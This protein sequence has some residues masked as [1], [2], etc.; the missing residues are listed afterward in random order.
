MTNKIRFKFNHITLLILCLLV[1]FAFVSAFGC[2][3]SGSKVEN[4]PPAKTTPVKKAKEVKPQSPFA[5][6]DVTLE[7]YPD[8]IK[9]YL[10]TRKWKTH[11]GYNDELTRQTLLESFKLG[12]AFMI[13]NQKPAGNFNY[14]YDFVTKTQDRGDNQVRQAGALWGLALTYQYKQDPA[15]KAALDKA[16]K[17]FFEHTRPGPIEGSLVVAYPGEKDSQSGTNALVALA[18]I[19]YLRTDKDTALN[20]PAEYKKQLKEKL[21]GYLKLLVWMKL[22]NKHFSKYYNL[23]TKT[24]TSRFSPY[25]DGETMLCLV[26]AA[27]YLGYKE[28]VPVIEDSALTL[29]KNYTID[30][31]KKNIDSND[32]KGF[33]Q[34]SCMTFWEYQDAGYK[35]HEAMGDYVLSLSWWMIHIHKT[36][37]RTRNTAYAYEG[38]IHAYKLAK[39][40]NMTEAVE[41]LGYT[42]DKGVRK[43]TSWQV[44]GPLENSFLRDHPTTDRFAVGGIMNHRKEPP[45]RIDVTQHQMHVVVLALKNKYMK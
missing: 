28:I 13:N 44:G 16:L 20:L 10:D 26:K 17:F 14:Q 40:R 19:E 9:T 30:A 38:I 23:L 35:H 27:K 22:P 33:F 8:W 11:K 43:L 36:L 25:F 6:T 3:N 7:Q 41:D 2:N 45:L 39:K 31:W 5:N 15:N 21:D 1:T 37:K 12:K 32:T 29:A 24:K 42:I 34:W 4:K 18:I